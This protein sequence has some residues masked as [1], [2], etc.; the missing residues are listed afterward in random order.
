MNIAARAT[1]NRRLAELRATHAQAR[2]TFLQNPTPRV[3][4]ILKS[5]EASIRYEER[6][7]K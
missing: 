2:R 3:G 4:S 1:E 6:K 5:L 7:K